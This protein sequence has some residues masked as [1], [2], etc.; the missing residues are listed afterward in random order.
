MPVLAECGP[1]R[2]LTAAVLAVSVTGCS[3]FEQVRRET[4]TPDSLRTLS[5]NQVAPLDRASPYLKVHMQ[6]GNVYVL[7]SWTV[8]RD[9]GQ[10]LGEGVQYRADRVRLREG[11]WALGL[12][13]VAIMETNRLTSSGAAAALTVITGVS[14]AVTAACIANPKACFGSCPT[15]Y[16]SG[17][18]G[19]QLR[20][21]G[22]S[23]SIAPSLEATDVDALFRAA[24]AGDRFAVEMR[25][26]ALETHVVRHVDLLAAPR[27]PGHRVFAALD[28]SFWA[29][30][31]LWSPT[32]A[33]GPEGGC[34]VPLSQAD[35][36][37][38]C[39][40]ADPVYLGAKETIELEFEG[41]PEGPRG[42]VVGC[43]QTLLST[44]LLYQT[45]AYM[46]SDVA[47]WLA[48]MGRK[49]AASRDLP[50]AKAIGGIEVAVRD[51]KGRWRVAGEI[52]EHGPLAL[53][54]H[55][56]PLG[57]PRRPSATTRVRLRLTKG[58]W[59]IDYV[60][61]A[62]LSQPVE[63]IR[64]APG[65]VRKDGLVDARACAALRDSAEVLTTL[66]GDVYTLEYQLPDVAPDYE[67]FLESRGYYL[68]WVRKEW[69]AEGN[70]RLLAQILRDPQTA[71]RRLAP[72]F[73]QAEAQM[74]DS[75]WR[76]RYAR[77]Y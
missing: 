54:Y 18:D 37:E 44:Y 3:A 25:N 29:S 45:F 10:L 58:N 72:E 43:R 67:L 60:A 19:L 74:E 53:D 32:A 33:T 63:P 64:I 51:A 24:G 31:R 77:P 50:I 14:A 75:F 30:P 70:P 6:N 8:Q 40:V 35:G 11:P 48:L 26:E 49:R 68:E 7:H 22:F 2:L 12:D 46:G 27:E 62:S 21:E 39:S 13:S 41:V 52:A 59:R 9:P 56:V 5:G 65:S 4:V 20:A 28:G 57:Q 23:A 17:E 61:L 16:V 47:R 71:L 73:K 36:I 69:I 1:Y 76:S 42:L 15:F 38:R 34:L 55:L 66:P